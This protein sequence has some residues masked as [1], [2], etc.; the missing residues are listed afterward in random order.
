MSQNT[1]IFKEKFELVSLLFCLNFCIYKYFIIF[2][3]PITL[4]Q[5]STT[6]NQQSLESIALPL[7]E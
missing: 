1:N 2:K 7:T 6:L 3:T 4:S 5:M